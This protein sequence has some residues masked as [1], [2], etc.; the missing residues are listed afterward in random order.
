MANKTLTLLA[1]WLGQ[2]GG[3]PR[4]VS[5]NPNS[6]N[7]FFDAHK[8]LYLYLQ[9]MYNVCTMYVQVLNK[10]V[11]WHGWE[12]N[13]YVYIPYNLYI[14]VCTLYVH[15][16]YLS[17]HGTDMFIILIVCMWFTSVHPGSP[18]SVHRL[19]SAVLGCTSFK[20]CYSTGICN[21]V[22]TVFIHVYTP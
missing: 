18:A 16:T 8:D 10:Y 7:F 11:H 21:L 4:V 9:C 2:P 3:L 14:R 22:H 13:V 12:Y 15:C 5:S 19:Y 1:Q 20:Q 17:V 6:S